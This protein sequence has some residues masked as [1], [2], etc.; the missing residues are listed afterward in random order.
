[1]SSKVLSDYTKLCPNDLKI[2]DNFFSFNDYHVN[3]SL[4]GSK[5]LSFTQDG[6]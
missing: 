5:Q 3:F 1:M 4:G 2:H 6:H